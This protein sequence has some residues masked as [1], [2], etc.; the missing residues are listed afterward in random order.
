MKTYIIFHN[1]IDGM[2]GGQMYVCNK[3]RYMERLGWSVV[4]FSSTDGPV[5]IPELDKHRK[6]IVPEMIL[7]PLVYSKQYAA[8]I[9]DRLLSLLPHREDCV[10]ESGSARMAFWGELLAQKLHCKHMVHLLYER[11]DEAIPESYLPYYWF[12]WERR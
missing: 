7:S 8:R 5:L 1:N 10:I 12:K 11:P 6:Y 2:G 9:T 4:I 3:A